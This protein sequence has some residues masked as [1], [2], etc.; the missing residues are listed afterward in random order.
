MKDD[1]DLIDNNNISSVSNNN[2]SEGVA[3]VSLPH[4][5]SQSS[6]IQ[7]NDDEY[8]DAY[9]NQ[10]DDFVDNQLNQ[11]ELSNQHYSHSS[12]L[13]S[14]PPLPPSPTPSQTSS[15]KSSSNLPP[16]PPVKQSSPKTRPIS[17]LVNDLDSTA[18]RSINEPHALVIASLRAQID[19]L[20]SQLNSLNSK[21]VK[22]FEKSDNLEFELD[23]S[24]SLIE[25]YKN[26]I[27]HLE[28]ER[29]QFKSNIDKGILVEREN[30]MQELSRMVDSIMTETAAATTAK[31]DKLNMQQD[32][33]DL[34]ADLFGEANRMVGV[35]RLLKA[36]EQER[37]KVAEERL[38]EAEDAIRSFQS[39]VKQWV[40]RA[41]KAEDK[42]KNT[43]NDESTSTP[44]KSKKNLNRSINEFEIIDNHIPYFEFQSFLISIAN[45][46]PLKTQNPNYSIP[47]LDLSQPFLRRVI[48]EDIEPTL[49]L[50]LSRAFGL[51]TRG[52]V[53]SSIV[54]GQ[55]ELEP[56]L[57]N[58]FPYG[59]ECALSSRILITNNDGN[60]DENNHNQDFKSNSL[61]SFRSRSITSIP[62]PPLK[63]K[64]NENIYIF[65]LSSAPNATRYPIDPI[66]ALPRLRSTCEF[67]RYIRNLQKSIINLNDNLSPNYDTLTLKSVFNNVNGNANDDNVNVKRNTLQRSFWG[68][69]G[70]SSNSNS[71]ANSQTASPS[72]SQL[73]SALPDVEQ[74]VENVQNEKQKEIGNEKKENENNKENDVKLDENYNNNNNNDNNNNVAEQQQLQQKQ[75]TKNQTNDGDEND[76]DNVE[77]LNNVKSKTP[78]RNRNKRGRKQT[79]SQAAAPTIEIPPTTATTNENNDNN[80]LSL[81]LN[82][83]ENENENEQI[84]QNEVS[85]SWELARW[86]QI[87]ELKHAMFWARVNGEKKVD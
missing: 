74:K 3:E 45:L 58:E 25:S 28:L 62:T 26:D 1:N 56:A 47:P 73:G 68:S 50:D 84:K 13:S 65:K 37:R 6:L 35:E 18:A 63:A 15:I 5:Q 27:N 80:T 76:K 57:K 83:N 60:V 53:L 46:I 34:S 77:E 20:K 11:L 39:Q 81:N 71:N 40:D 70:R 29:S 87:L 85:D 19:D 49:R 2:G 23:H 38:L 55:L 24:K 82:S 51:L 30:V 67:W 61:F 72:T 48:E 4:D 43:S 32:L 14:L 78:K 22:S 21:L 33:D 41:E 8:E 10:E 86:K 17:L 69:F 59:T 79:V 64:P 44:S 66:W 52:K 54:E 12:Q 16:S 75:E 7:Y 42:L 9:D 31:Q 36:Q